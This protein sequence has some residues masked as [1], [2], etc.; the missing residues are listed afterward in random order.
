MAASQVEKLQRMR[1]LTAELSQA[2]KDLDD[3]ELTTD[4]AKRK[5]EELTLEA[6]SLER[7]IRLFT[8]KLA[9]LRVNER[10][11]VNKAETA[12]ERIRQY[13][14]QHD[15]ASRED[16]ASKLALR[17]RRA[18]DAYRHQKR[19]QIRQSVEDHLNSRIPVLLAPSQLIRSVS[20]SDSFEMKYFDEHGDEVARSSISAGMRQ[21]VAMGMLWA[22]RDEAGRDV[23]VVIDTPLGRIDRENRMLLMDEYFPKAGMPLIL[24]PTNS[25]LDD[26]DLLHLQPHICRR[27]RIVNVGGTQARIELDSDGL[28]AG[29]AR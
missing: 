12:K 7:Q 17:V 6:E 29:A 27:Y 24:L 5:F 28:S 16:V 10:Q 4:E 23:P 2:Q 25:E 13:E 19:A 11:A 18:V 20:L 14:Q 26:N 1:A 3:A 15:I 9:E 22:L 8:D 21:L